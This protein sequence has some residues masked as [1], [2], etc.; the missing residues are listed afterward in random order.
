VNK[1]W[2]NTKLCG[3]RNRPGKKKIQ[4]WCRVEKTSTNKEGEGRAPTAGERRTEPGNLKG[5][6][7]K[8]GR[9]TLHWTL[10][11]S[12]VAPVKKREVLTRTGA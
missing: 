9:A 3:R 5:K 6:R 12:V 8:G 7:P 1:K 4:E 10:V 11:Q 2:S